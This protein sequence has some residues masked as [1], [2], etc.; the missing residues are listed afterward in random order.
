MRIEPAPD[1]EMRA[2][3]DFE[4]SIAQEKASIW[5]GALTATTGCPTAVSEKNAATSFSV[6]RRRTPSPGN[7]CS[8]ALL[9]NCS[10]EF[11]AGDV[12]MRFKTRA[13]FAEE[14]SPQSFL[15]DQELN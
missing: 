10:R 1:L 9:L 7:C 4:R 11:W 8:T 12:S 6:A 13:N 14:R 5:V 3:E 2:H 15:H